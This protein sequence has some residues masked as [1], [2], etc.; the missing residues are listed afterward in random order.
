LIFIGPTC[1]VESLRPVFEC[2]NNENEQG[3]Q[4]I[5]ASACD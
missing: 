2:E 1:S 4:Y 5:Y 3:A